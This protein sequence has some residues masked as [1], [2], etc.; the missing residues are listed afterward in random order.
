VV[1]NIKELINKVLPHFDNFPL[2]SSKYLNYVDFKK[3]ALI[4]F[5]KEHYTYNGIIKL[6]EIKAKMNRARTFDDKFNFC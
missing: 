3:A 6:K 4:M 2:Q 5:E 1:T